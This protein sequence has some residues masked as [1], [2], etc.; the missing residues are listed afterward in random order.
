MSKRHLA[1]HSFAVS[2][3]CFAFM[4]LPLCAPLL[5]AGRLGLTGSYR[6]EKA[7]ELGQDVQ[8]TLRL[9][10]IN[11]DDAT[12]SA[13]ELKLD[14]A[15]TVG[16]KAKDMGGVSLPA[17]GRQALSKQVLISKRQYAALKA[18]SSISLSLELD[19]SGSKRNGRTILLTAEREVKTAS[20]VQAAAS[21]QTTRQ[22]TAVRARTKPTLS[23]QSSIISTIAGGGP[24]NVAALNAPL[25]YAWGLAADQ[26]G[27]TYVAVGNASRVFKVDANGTLTV[28]A[29]NGAW[30]SS[31]DGGPATQAELGGPVAV[32]VDA[33]GNVF[34]SANYVIREVTPDGTIQTVAG[35]GCFGYSGDGGPAAQ[36][37][38]GY[39]NAIAVSG[40]NVFIADTYNNAVRQFTVGGMIQTVAGTGTPGYSGDGGLAVRAQLSGPL[41]LAIDP[42]GNLFIAD[43]TSVIR[44]VTPDGWI[45]PFAS[46]VN[47]PDGSTAGISPFS[48]VALDTEVI[49]ASDQNEVVI[50]FNGAGPGVVVAGTYGVAEG[51]PPYFPPPTSEPAT[52]AHFYGTYGL[53]IDVYGNVLVTD[54]YNKRVR[55]FSI[56]GNMQ[57]FAGNGL[58]YYGGDNGPATDAVLASERDMCGGWPCPRVTVNGAGNVVLSDTIN[59]AIRQVDSAGNIAT[60]AGQPA[61]GYGG[62]W[63]DEG[64]ATKAGLSRSEGVTYDKDGNLYIADTQNSLIRKVTIDG[65]IHTIAGDGDSDFYG[66]Y[67]PATAAAL[68]APEGVAVDS[69][70]NVFI[71]DTQN[72]VVRRV[73]A[74]TQNITT[75]AGSI[76]QL[77]SSYTYTGDNGLA[78]SATLSVPRAVTLDAAGNLFIADT[79]NQAIR[80]VDATTQIIT[81]VAGTGD[82]GYNGDGGPAVSSRLSYP[83]DVVVDGA[84]NLFIADT[85]NNLVREVTTNGNIYIVAGNGSMWIGHGC[86]ARPADWRRRG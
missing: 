34:I 67:G 70:G 39:P 9:E 42:K 55:Q 3:L 81:T 8:V 4:L 72:C 11:S 28:F 44:E 16:S 56:G 50:E 54:T 79:Y 26:F 14:P 48:L 68:N 21:F 41:G 52:Q 17:R 1:P 29:G 35:N 27:N 85:M 63:G 40:N 86:C 58:L 31:G 2:A 84:G 12:F 49:L 43:Q 23:S 76:S 45:W 18:G 82:N 69:L 78:T 73:D 20:A 7:V 38:L 47:L 37:C 30:G 5:A 57:T 22:K 66:D 83:S 62:Y 51:W 59:D 36:A 80:R 71:A 74:L 61:L 32:A 10:L 64:P 53:A 6:I 60:I 25:D 65:Y 33:A 24:N 15:V 77:C 46:S 75:Y 19:G 13:R